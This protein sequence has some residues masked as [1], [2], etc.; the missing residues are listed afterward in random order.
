MEVPDPGRASRRGYIQS[1]FHGSLSDLDDRDRLTSRP[2]SAQK[3]QATLKRTTWQK[4]KDRPLHLKKASISKTMM[5]AT[6]ISTDLD[7]GR[8]PELKSVEISDANIIVYEKQRCT[9]LRLVSASYIKT[10]RFSV[11]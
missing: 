11:A 3:S 2:I 1:V 9:F 6:E 8:R 4:R 5:L 7:S 10:L